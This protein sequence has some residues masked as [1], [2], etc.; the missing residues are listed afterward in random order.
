M[1][2]RLTRSA[3]PADRRYSRERIWVMPAAAPGTLRVGVAF[4][5]WGEEARTAYFIDHLQRG[6]LVARK[7][8]GSIDV[9]M[10]RIELVAPLS[11]RIVASNAALAEDPALASRDPFG[12]G[13][14][15]E[16]TR[17]APGDYE[18]LYDRD[19]FFAYLQFEMEARRLGLSPTLGARCRFEEGDP[20]PQDLRVELGG[21]LIVRT[22]AV[23]F[24][25]NETFTP[26]W[27]VGDRWRV[28]C[29]VLQPSAA[30]MHAEFAPPKVIERT[31]AY[32]VIDD[33][34]D[35]GGEPCYVLRVIEVEGAPPLT[36]YRVFIA[37][38]DFTLRLVEEESVHDA[39]RRTRTPNDWGAEGFLELRKPRELILDLPLFPAE[40]RDERRLVNVAGE[41]SYEQLT[42]F[43]DPA[44]MVISCEAPLREGRI[45][46]EQT[47]RR[48]LPWWKSA[49]RTT[50][51]RVLISGELL[52]V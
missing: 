7:P 42:R 17:V 5:A 25:R 44:T 30:K 45:R 23:K 33:A 11:G 1:A 24:G 12:A 4:P 50:G 35:L 48:G 2:K 32:E 37:K 41:P 28:R 38:Q 6:Y 51:E 47:W 39:R 19:G 15:C 26:Q 52:G 3:F 18:K 43:P 21:R 31:W 20:W 49:R 13:W 8:F 14:L 46:S 16:I 22:R 9:E 29:E 34:A 27:A 40:N 10:G 36:F